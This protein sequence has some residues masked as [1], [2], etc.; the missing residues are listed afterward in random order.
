MAK[1]EFEI[2]NFAVIKVIGC[3]GG[4]GNAVNRMI[5]AGLTGV[6]FLSVNTDRQALVANQAG[7]KLQ[8]GEKIT[9][10]LGAG[11]NPDVG[12]RAAEESRDEIIERLRGVNMVFV[13]AGMGGGT[14]TGAAPIIANIAREMGILTVGVVTR[15]FGF[16][17]RVRAVNAERGINALVQ[18]VDALVIIPNERL[19]GVVGK[20]TPIT[21]AF[22]FADD[23][24]RQGIS[25]I[26]DLISKPML[27][28][29]DFADVRK[30]MQDAGLAHMGIGAASGDNRAMDAAKQAIQSPL[31]ETSINGARGVIINIMGSEDLELLEV[32]EAASMIQEAADPDCEIIFGAGI[33]TD[34]KDEIRITVI[35]TGFGEPRVYTSQPQQTFRR[36]G[37]GFPAPLRPQSQAAVPG[38]PGLGRLPGAN[39][40]QNIPAATEEPDPPAQEAV[41][42]PKQKDEPA[43]GT[44]QFDSMPPLPAPDVKKSDARPDPQLP[45]FIFEESE[46]TGLPSDY[47]ADQPPNEMSEITQPAFDIPAF[48]RRKKDKD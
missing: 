15:P 4:G 31:L 3:G 48:L 10:G 11:A 1:S 19:L 30:V 46:E 47:S 41:Q 25:G 32:E 5:Q 18:N 40:P 6:E 16:E 2:N 20:G 44:G 27:I 28:N 43:P 45:S 42:E 26:S 12:E 7:D 35:A 21:Q 13:T 29:L 9:R 22:R 38:Y 39:G 17:G 23:V 33:D 34:L 8:I 37:Q 14:G 24:L 36:P